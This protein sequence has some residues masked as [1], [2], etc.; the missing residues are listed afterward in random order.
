MKLFEFKSLALILILSLFSPPGYSI[1]LEE[2]QELRLAKAELAYVDG[3]QA[4]ALKLLAE[5]IT[6]KNFHLETY[7][8][9]AKI[10]FQNKEYAKG[11]R[12]YYYAIKQLHTDKLLR[13]RIIDL[14]KRIDDVE[15]PSPETLSLYIKVANKYYDLYENK[16]YPEASDEMLL[17]LSYKYFS[18]LEHYKYDPANTKYMMARI[19]QKLKNYNVALE[20]M[21]EAKELFIELDE[22]EGVKDASYADLDYEIG[23]ILIQSGHMDAGGIYLKTLFLNPKTTPALREYASVYL[24]SLSQTYSVTTFTLGFTD[25]GNLNELNTTQLANFSADSTYK[26]KTATARTLGAS[27]FQS[28]DQYGNWQFFGSGSFSQVNY[29]HEEVTNNDFRS[30]A[31]A[32]DIKY[33]NLSMS[34]GKLGY[35]GSLSYLRQSVGGEFAKYSLSHSIYLQYSYA[36]KSGLLSIKAPITLTDYV[37]TSLNDTYDLGGE[38]SLTPYKVGKYWS[39]TYSLSYTNAGDT[40]YTERSNQITAAVS[41]HMKFSDTS[42]LFIEPSYTTFTNSVASNTYNELAIYG[43]WSIY[44]AKFLGISQSL[45]TSWSQKT[46]GNGSIVNVST[47]S[48][49]WSF[50]F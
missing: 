22:K 13:S 17:G 41:N 19:S 30:F 7:L 23:D 6:R 27:Y 28:S 26:R 5:N 14:K 12:S 50:N 11:F 36:L 39:P 49:N 47:T 8:F 29:L 31:L 32:F 37:S 20:K 43:S 33:D 3:D 40:Y 24:E 4:T 46:Y 25:Y 34:I 10:H 9:I 15:A 18:I 21:I 2:L 1:P 44:F 38:L 35:Y 45:N 16:S 48:I 42:S